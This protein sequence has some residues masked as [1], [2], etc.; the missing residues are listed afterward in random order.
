VYPSAQARKAVPPDVEQP[1]PVTG[2]PFG[3][4]QTLSVQTV[5]TV[6]VQ[7]VVD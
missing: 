6:V 5:S 2:E 7:L 3:Q 4:T 1:E